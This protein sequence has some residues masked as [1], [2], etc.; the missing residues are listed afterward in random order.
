VSVKASETLWRNRGL[1]NGAAVRWKALTEQRVS[2]VNEE[3][4]HNCAREPFRSEV[5]IGLALDA[6]K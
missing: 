3:M 5:C 2:R 4:T 1:V 6:W